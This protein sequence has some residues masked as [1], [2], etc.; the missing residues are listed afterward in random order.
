VKYCS[1]RSKVGECDRSRDWDSFFV[2]RSR[3]AVQH[4]IKKAYVAPVV[5]AVQDSELRVN[6]KKIARHH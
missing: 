1:D 4:Y 3:K 6:L 5:E 2:D